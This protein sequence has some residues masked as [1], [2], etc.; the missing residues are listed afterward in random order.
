MHIILEGHPCLQV[1]KDLHIIQMYKT[2]CKMN[3]ISSVEVDEIIA[4]KNF[5]GS[6]N[7]KILERIPK[8]C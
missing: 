4:S 3:I 1:I 2:F 8:K 7:V 6:S 5:L